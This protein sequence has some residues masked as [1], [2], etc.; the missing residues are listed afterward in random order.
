MLF[1][2][3]PVEAVDM[4]RGVCVNGFC[5]I[6]LGSHVG[7]GFL[8]WGQAAVFAH[9]P[10]LTKGGFVISAITV[11]QGVLVCVSPALADWCGMG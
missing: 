1:H 5:S 2:S 6:S 10:E 9:S 8:G 4:L 11:Q 3:A 7:S